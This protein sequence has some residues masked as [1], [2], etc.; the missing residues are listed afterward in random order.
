MVALRS[1]AHEA[2]H[3]ASRHFDRLNVRL[4][5]RRI[6]G[7]GSDPNHE[8]PTSLTEQHMCPRTMKHRPP[9]IFLSATSVPPDSSSRT[10]SAVFSSYAICPARSS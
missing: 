7:A 5:Q 8:A 3:G 2:G 10:R 4:G 1:D 6:L 9:I